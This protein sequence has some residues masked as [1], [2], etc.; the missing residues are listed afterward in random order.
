M[1]T[2]GD[3]VTLLLTFFVF[4]FALSTVESKKFEAAI[5]SLQNAFG[6]PLSVEEIPLGPQSQDN[7][8]TDSFWNDDLLTEDLRQL[9]E[10]ERRLRAY[11]S[12]ERM[13]TLIDLN[14]EGRGLVLRFADT[15]LFDLG[16][17]NLKPEARAILDRLSTI[18]RDVPNHIRVEG[19]T[20]DLPIKTGLFPSNWELSTRRATEV[21]RHF[22]EAHEFSP[23]RLSAAGY[24]EYRPLAPNDSEANRQRNRRVDVVIL[25]LSLS[26]NEPGYGR[27]AGESEKRE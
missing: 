14:R 24:A 7:A 1:T 5:V 25:R 8:V 11:I 19:H 12:E 6:L 2:Y 4:L 15:V 3:M 13:D 20:D 16:K 23:E 26:M 10:I 17:A 21:I 22:V 9:L 18:T 27:G